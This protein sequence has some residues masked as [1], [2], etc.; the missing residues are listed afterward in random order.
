[1][2]IKHWETFLFVVIYHLLLVILA[3]FAVAD[4]SWTAFG[5]FFIPYCVAGSIDHCGIP[6]AFFT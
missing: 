3:P 2:Q 4:F 6:Q 5:V 1:M